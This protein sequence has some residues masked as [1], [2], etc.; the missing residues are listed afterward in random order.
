[1]RIAAAWIGA[2]VALFF[3]VSLGEPAARATIVERVVAVIGERPILW[4]ELVHRALAGR[5]QIRTQT[6]DQNVISVQEQEMYKELLNRMIDDRLEEQ[7]ADR[8][9]LT[10]TQDE[11]DRGMQNIAMQAQQ[12][13][14]RPVTVADVL[15]EVRRRG[16][17]E[18]DFRDEIRRQILE[19]KLIELRVRPRVRVTDQDAHAAYQHWATEM[20]EQ[21]PID[22]RILALRIPPTSTRLQSDARYLLAEELVRRARGGE[23]FCT[24]VTQYSDD[25]S[26]R[27]SCGSHGTQPTANL[28]PAIQEAIKTMQPGT[29]SDPIGVTT[30]QEQ[31]LVILMPM[32][33]TKTPNY[34][35]VKNEMMQR[36]LLEGLEHAR[37]QWLQELR[38]NVY[39]DIRL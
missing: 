36:A 3:L 21:Q 4:T 29:I 26:T 23:D 31:A 1:M 10:A 13:Q 30:G 19:G 25:V 18:Q 16:L 14:G 12:Q 7:Q 8:A 35:E 39:I 22:V 24:L 37:K 15:D 34:D 27:D 11:I 32:G 20:R 33:Q 9:H 17:T 6:Q 28:L 2:C 5:V 38:R